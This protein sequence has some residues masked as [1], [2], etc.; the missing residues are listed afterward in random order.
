MIDGG[1]INIGQSFTAQDNLRVFPFAIDCVV[2]TEKAGRTLELEYVGGTGDSADE[3]RRLRGPG[4]PTATGYAARLTTF[5]ADDLGFV[6]I[7]IRP[8]VPF[9]RCEVNGDGVVDQSDAVTLLRH[10]FLGGTTTQCLLA[11]DCN[12]QDGVD[13]NDAIF[14]L[15]YYFLGGAQPPAPFPICGGGDGVEFEQGPERSTACGF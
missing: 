10:L 2:P 4:Q 13:M 8:G 11:A 1:L 5:P 9:L 6:S 7:T 12:G 14:N 3:A 15:E